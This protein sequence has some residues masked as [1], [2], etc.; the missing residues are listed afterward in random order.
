MAYPVSSSVPPL[1][2]VPRGKV[3]RAKLADITEI[4][5]PADTIGKEAV[6]RA[7][8]V[9]VDLTGKEAVLRAEIALA[10]LAVSSAPVDLAAAVP[11]CL[12][13]PRRG[14]SAIMTPT[15]PTIFGYLITISGAK[16]R[17]PWIK[18]A[19]LR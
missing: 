10:G 13:L 14:G 2:A 7:E 19:V 3:D 17:K 15:V 12:R 5:V 1:E 18:S 11:P 16:I 6:P 9:P 4:S 8:I